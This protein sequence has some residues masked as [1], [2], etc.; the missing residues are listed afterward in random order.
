MALSLWERDQASSVDAQEQISGGRAASLTSSLP[1]HNHCHSPWWMIPFSSRAWPKLTPSSVLLIS[2][3]SRSQATNSLPETEDAGEM[4]PNP[5]T[6]TQLAWSHPPQEWQADF[7]TAHKASSHSP[8]NY[9]KA[10]LLFQ[11]ARTIPGQPHPPRKGW[12]DGWTDGRQM[13]RWMDDR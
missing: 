10:C 4:V 12:V 8:R 2:P 3:I 11:V 13:N 9:D 7:P 1:R 5:R 6:K